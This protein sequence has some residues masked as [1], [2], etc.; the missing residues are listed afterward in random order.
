MQNLLVKLIV[1]AG[2]EIR[3]TFCSIGTTGLICT[4]GF[5][6]ANTG[7]ASANLRGSLIFTEFS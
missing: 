3:G 6:T 4:L 2:I 5:A 1:K 7:F